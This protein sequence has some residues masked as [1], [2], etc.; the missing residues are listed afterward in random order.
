[1]EAAENA[2]P[3]TPP[4]ATAP[5]DRRDAQFALRGRKARAAPVGM[6][7]FLG[8]RCRGSRA[9]TE[10]DRDN[11]EGWAVPLLYL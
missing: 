11:R 10:C 9:G 7:S 6:T 1:M 2:D 8:Q 4:R 3:S 5:Q